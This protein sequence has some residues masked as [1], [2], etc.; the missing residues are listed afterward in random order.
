MTDPRKSCIDDI[1]AAAGEGMTREE[2]EK[3][4]TD[5][6]CRRRRGAWQ[7][8]RLG[9]RRGAGHGSRRWRAIEDEIFLVKHEVDLRAEGVPTRSVGFGMPRR[10]RSRR[11]CISCGLPLEN[12]LCEVRYRGK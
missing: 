8:G 7:E 6:S 1:P 4:L 11:S 5:L 9:R 12:I 3:I 10:W 2:V